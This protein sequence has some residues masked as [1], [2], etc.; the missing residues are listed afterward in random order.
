MKKVFSLVIDHLD[1]VDYKVWYNTPDI[2]DLN[3]WFGADS[4]QC[5][6]LEEKRRLCPVPVEIVNINHK[7]KDGRDFAHMQDLSF[8]YMKET[9]DPDV[10]ILQSA[11]ELLTQKGKDFVLDWIDNSE[12]QFCTL[13]AMSNKLFCETFIAPLPFQMFRKGVEY[14]SNNGLSDNIRWCNGVNIA[15]NM[16]HTNL[17]YSDQEKD[18]LVIDCGYIDAFACYQKTKNWGGR[19]CYHDDFTDELIKLWESGDK[20]AFI[21]LF[22]RKTR[23]EFHGASDK[24]IT[25]VKYE[26][27]YKKMID[28]LGLKD[29]YDY[30]VE[31]LKTIE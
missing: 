23:A 17:G 11:D 9:Y 24:K 8:K 1:K 4:H 5:E 28:D 7:I 10:F 2:F 20:E 6:L 19:L 30:T 12:E 16:H 21:K 26:G 15:E 3:L 25:P 22:V 31:I 29:E 27:E 14:K 13:A 18:N